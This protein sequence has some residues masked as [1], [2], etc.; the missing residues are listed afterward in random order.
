MPLNAAR[1]VYGTIV[2]AVLLSAETAAKETYGKTLVAVMLAV[3]AYWFAHSYAES[4]AGR[5]SNRSQLTVAELLHSMR[6]E[7]P[8]VLG[9][10]L[11]LVPVLISWIA[12]SSLSTAVSDAIWTAAALIV[13]YEFVAGLRAELSGVRLIAQTLVGAALGVLVIVLKLVIH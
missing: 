11:P 5:M 12:G 6:H 7:L 10:T 2:V 3:L 1:V 9:A 13:V 4:A 8:I